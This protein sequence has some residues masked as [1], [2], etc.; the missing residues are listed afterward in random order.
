MDAG[1]LRTLL[2]LAVAGVVVI[3]GVLFAAWKRARG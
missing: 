1:M 2:L 3:V